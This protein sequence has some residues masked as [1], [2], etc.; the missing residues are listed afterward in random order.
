M[1]LLYHLVAVFT[2]IIF[3]HARFTNKLK[4]YLYLII[5]LFHYFLFSTIASSYV[6]KTTNVRIFIKQIRTFPT[7]SL[8]ASLFPLLALVPIPYSYPYHYSS[9]STSL[10]VYHKELQKKYL[11][12]CYTRIIRPKSIV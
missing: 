12:R 6:I 4:C 3:N 1:M 5:P 7:H 8:Y 11:L 10:M 9:F 2:S